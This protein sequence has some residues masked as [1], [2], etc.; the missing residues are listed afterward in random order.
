[1]T[2]KKWHML[3]KFFKIGE[4]ILKNV[5]RIVNEVLS[6]CLKKHTKVIM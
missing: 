5:L 3:E 1:M 2:L 6:L 4:K